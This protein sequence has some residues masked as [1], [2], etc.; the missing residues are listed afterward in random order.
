MNF[1]VWIAAGYLF[2]HS[3]FWILGNIEKMANG[4]NGSSKNENLEEVSGYL[5][6]YNY[7]RIFLV[8]KT[9]YRIEVKTSSCKWAG[10]PRYIFLKRNWKAELVPVK[11]DSFK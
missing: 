6:N 8:R 3:W 9:K 7:I 10:L 2:S 5:K 4:M 11:Y 1:P